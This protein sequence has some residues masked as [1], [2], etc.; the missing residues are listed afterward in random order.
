MG[1]GKK[2]KDKMKVILSIVIILLVLFIVG[3]FV[4][5]PAI[6]KRDANR[7]NEGIQYAIITLMQQVATC[8]PVPLT[9][10]NQTINVIAIECL[11]QE[12]TTGK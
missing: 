12:Q 2:P 11:Q 10:E 5:K 1:E 4:I 8:N 9:F 3:M 6:E 7:V